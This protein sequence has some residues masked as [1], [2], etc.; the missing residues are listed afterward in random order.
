MG[1]I[2]RFIPNKMKI[3]NDKDPPWITPVIKTAI[4]RKHRAYNK[5]A[6]RGQ[7]LDEWE[8]VR[9]IGN[10]TS[11]IITDAKASYFSALGRNS[12]IRL[13]VLTL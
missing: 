3:C 7:K 1:I 8:P 2:S 4:K 6:K 9:M 13:L 5:F 12:L 10:E 11:R